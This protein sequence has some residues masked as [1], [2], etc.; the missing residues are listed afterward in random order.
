MPEK[1][2]IADVCKIH[3]LG[4][5][6]WCLK[7]FKFPSVLRNSMTHEVVKLL[8][9]KPI[10]VTFLKFHM[11]K[12]FHILES[13]ILVTYYLMSSI[14]PSIKFQKDRT[15]RFRLPCQHLD[16]SDALPKRR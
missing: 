13:F 4:S 15:S 14:G 8:Q 11:F 3:D 16:Y 1:S 9:M 7:D 5:G 10:K 2:Y 6:V 12:T